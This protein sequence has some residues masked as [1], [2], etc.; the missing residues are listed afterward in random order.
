MTNCYTNC[1]VGNQEKKKKA[2]E[3]FNNIILDK[4]NLQH[5]AVELDV[6][7]IQVFIDNPE[8]YYKSFLTRKF[9]TKWARQVDLGEFFND[10]TETWTD[11]GGVIIKNEYTGKPRVVPFNTIA[12]VDQTNIMKGPICEKLFLSPD[13]LMEYEGKW[14]NIE[15]AIMLA[16]KNHQEIEAGR[17]K[18]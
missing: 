18:K 17:K 13:E 3:T 14:N 7:D 4:I 9:H 11:Y 16:T 10:V 8:E 5:R 12:F 6:V 1:H 15:L 2:K